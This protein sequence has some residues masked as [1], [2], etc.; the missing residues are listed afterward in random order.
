MELYCFYV[1]LSHSDSHILLLKYGR[2]GLLW[3]LTD[4]CLQYICTLNTNI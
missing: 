2:M 4:I 1:I 3:L